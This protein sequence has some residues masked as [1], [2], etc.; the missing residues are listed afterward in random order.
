ML[1]RWKEYY[2][3]KRSGLFDPTYYLLNNPDVRQADV[4]PLTHFIEHGWREGRN[5]SQKFYTNYYLEMYEDVKIASINPLVH[6]LEFGKKEGRRTQPV[7]QFLLS[8]EFQISSGKIKMTQNEKANEIAVVLHMFYEDLFEEITSYLQNLDHFDLYVSM[9]ESNRKFSDKIFAS[10]P[11]AKILFTKNRGRDIFPFISIYRNISLLNYK[12]LLKIHTKKST[13]REDGDAW[14][15]DIYRKLI[16]SAEIINSIILAFENNQTIGIIAPKGHVV[17]YQTYTWPINRLKNEELA[18]KAGINIKEITSFNFVAGSMFWVKPEA[19]QY[20]KLLSIELEDFEPEPLKPDGALVHA[21]E[22]FIGLAVEEKGYSIYESDELGKISESKR[23]SSNDNYPFGLPYIPKIS[24]EENIMQPQDLYTYK[25]ESYIRKF[26]LWVFPIGSKREKM[27]KVLIEDIKTRNPKLGNKIKQLF[28]FILIKE[29]PHHLGSDQREI[30]S[31]TLIVNPEQLSEKLLEYLVNDEYVISLSHDNYTGI[32][33][34]VQLAVMDEQVAYNKR[35]IDYLHIYPLITNPR[36]LLNSE[37]FKIGLNCNG[38]DIGAINSEKFLNV[39][40]RL[41]SKQL[42]NVLIHHTMGFEISLIYRILDE[43]GNKNGRFWIH[44]FFTLC[45]SYTLLCN[46]LFFCSAPNVNS[47]ACLIC[48]YGKTRRIQQHA[49]SKLF[50]DYDLEIVAP[51]VFTLDFWKE[52]SSFPFKSD[53]VIPHIILDWDG[54]EQARP[55]NAPLRIGFVG[56]PVYWK[57]WETW[58]KLVDKFSNDVRYQFYG[59][60]SWSSTSDRMKFVNVSVTKDNRLAM[61]KAL[62]ENQID[63]AFLWSLCPETFSFTLYESLAAGCYVLTYKDSGNIQAYIKQ[64][65][66]RG[67]VLENEEALFKLFSSNDLD[68]LVKDY[69]KNGR[70]LGELSFLPKNEWLD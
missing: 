55:I 34:G 69:Q 5:P 66:Q 49:F 42:L 35:G 67:L 50:N 30:N 44:D 19:L 36:L 53:K 12:Y 60:T 33:G 43:I 62:K 39:L 15:T 11:D 7:Q 58:L 52:K 48:K 3:I 27:A 61:V 38:K 18:R 56:Y 2:L 37:P 14:R 47:N 22:R 46:D 70:P 8:S 13:Y 68:I 16:G 51:S 28:R 32:I 23:G 54:T 29:K 63:I 6:Y 1:R 24:G 9:P 17:D 59:F 31:T 10:F 21:L 4:D 41:T 45:P 65:K 57:G 26:W 64:N 20:L 40:K 25:G